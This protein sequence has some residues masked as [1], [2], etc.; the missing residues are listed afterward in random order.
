MPLIT[1]PTVEEHRSRQHAL[2]LETARQLLLEE[3]PGAVT[4]AT[5]GARAGLARS[6]VYN[7]FRSS[8]DIFAQL[9][10]AAFARWDAQL[11]AA[12]AEQPT[13]EA[14]IRA[15]VR[16]MLD[17]A[18]GGEHVIG[19]ILGTLDLPA[20][21]VESIEEAHS[22]L[23]DPLRAALREL[24][25]PDPETAAALAYGVLD[26]AIRR[27][28]S[29]VRSQEI[30]AAAITFLERGLGAEGAPLPSIPPER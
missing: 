4:P 27:I 8:A 30:A 9:A 21:C 16:T 11:R 15:Y 2:L 3:G 10:Q 23:L 28:D 1:A 13:P 29:G 18:T 22:G 12:V 14:Q 20:E 5:V 26:A 17:L 25:D 6:S 7:Y 19:E 24:G